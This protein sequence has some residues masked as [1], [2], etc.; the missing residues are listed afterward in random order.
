MGELCFIAT[1][2]LLPLE[3]SNHAVDTLDLQT[4]G[5]KKKKKKKVSPLPFL[6]FQLLAAIIGC[7]ACVPVRVCA[8]SASCDWFGWSWV[9]LRVRACVLTRACDSCVISVRDKCACVCV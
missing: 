3:R 9:A 8:L 5:T 1:A 7:A 6:H 2:L 4:K